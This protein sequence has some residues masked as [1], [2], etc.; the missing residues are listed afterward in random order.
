M[1]GANF[2]RTSA[3][4]GSRPFYDVPWNELIMDLT[5]CINGSNLPDK[6]NSGDNDYGRH[7]ESA[8]ACLRQDIPVAGELGCLKALILKKVCDCGYRLFTRCECLWR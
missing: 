1:R 7:Y 6:Y 3:S 4:E 8:A 5:D 2:A